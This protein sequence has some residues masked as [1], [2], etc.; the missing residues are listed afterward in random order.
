MVIV[1]WSIP[2]Q[3]LDGFCKE[4]RDLP[5]SAS[6]AISSLSVA[7]QTEE[8][9]PV[10]VTA[11]RDLLKRLTLP[12]RAMFFRGILFDPPLARMSADMCGFLTYNGFLRTNNLLAIIVEEIC[13]IC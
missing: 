9:P 3:K 7:T 4:I 2:R 13:T 6:F 11:R 8:K 1:F 12:T 5:L 10:S